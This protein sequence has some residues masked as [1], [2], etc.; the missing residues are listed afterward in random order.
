MFVS[1][2]GIRNWLARWFGPRHD[3]AQAN[4]RGVQTASSPLQEQGPLFS[5]GDTKQ[6]VVVSYRGGE[7][8]K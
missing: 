5:L 1:H 3:A 8:D 7:A 4:E 6:D 2:I